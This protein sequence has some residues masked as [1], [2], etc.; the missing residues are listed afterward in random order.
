MSP[1]TTEPSAPATDTES[2]HQLA[3]QVLDGEPVDHQQALSIL[4][5]PD[6]Q[7]LEVLALGRGGETGRAGVGDDRQGCLAGEGGFVTLPPSRHTTT[8]MRVIELFTGLRFRCDRTG[9]RR[10]RIALG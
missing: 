9:D 7:L 3:E 1:Y 10:W 6:E 2:W 5:C 4:R 8:N